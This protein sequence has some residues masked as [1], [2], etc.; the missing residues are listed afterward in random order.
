MKKSVSGLTFA[1][2][3]LGLAMGTAT[4]RGQAPEQVGPATASAELAERLKSL[5]LQPKTL[6]EKY[7]HAITLQAEYRG[8][9]ER[10]FSTQTYTIWAIG[11][12]LTAMLFVAGRVGLSA[13]E[14]QTEA[15]IKS[16]ATELR[17]SMEE[18]LRAETGVLGQRGEKQVS[19]AIDRLT[20]EFRAKL[21]EVRLDMEARLLAN[22]A[23]T[24]AALDQHDDAIQ[25]FRSFLGQYAGQAD[26]KVIPKD[27]C[28]AV[29]QNLFTSLYRREPGK[30]REAAQ[31]ELSRE[32]YGSLREEVIL[33]GH[34]DEELR[35]VLSEI[36][37]KLTPDKP[38][39]QASTK[40][41]PEEKA[42]T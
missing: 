6:D 7:A 23:T 41:E 15:V 32:L 18:R 42:Q 27:A 10:A 20:K 14:K 26:V 8:F 36:D 34:G 2:L 4:A 24:F 35:G 13:F 29:I 39:D 3:L 12:L 9:Y 28:I 38:A 22:S 25:Q 1:T 30:F 37:W 33:A 19:D 40:K 16:A 17:V 21:A 31:Q 5:E 11:I